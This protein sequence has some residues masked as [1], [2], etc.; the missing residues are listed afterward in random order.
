LGVRE[1]SKRRVAFPKEDLPQGARKVITLHRRE[2]VVV[3]SDAGLFAVFNR[4]PHQQGPLHAGRITGAVLPSGKVGEF[5]YGLVG[6]V[7]RCPWHRYE[8]DLATGR[9]LADPERLRIATYKVR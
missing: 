6:G 5:T 7:L 3:N 8:Y 1:T 4:C 9:C 2:I